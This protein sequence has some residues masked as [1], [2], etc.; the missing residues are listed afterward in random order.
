MPKSVVVNP[1][2]HW[3]N[4][5]APGTPLEDTII[6]EVHV[7]GFTQRMDGIPEELRGTY[8]GLAHPIA[9]QHLRRLGVTAIEL[10]PIADFP[11]RWNWGYDGVAL[12]APAR[13]YGTPDDLRHL[14]DR[15]HGLGYGDAR[16]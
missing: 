4:D 6:Y 1:Y 12:F 10:M 15:A 7:K 16:Q 2:F 5:H 14:I 13:C 8:A 9:I 3:G 11:G